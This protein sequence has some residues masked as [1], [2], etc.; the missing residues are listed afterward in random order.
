MN[1]TPKGVTIVK[2]GGSNTSNSVP[3]A[4]SNAAQTPAVP[5]VANGVTQNSPPNVPLVGYTRRAKL[6][7][8]RSTGRLHTSSN[9]HRSMTKLNIAGIIHDQLNYLLLYINFTL[10]IYILGGSVGGLHKSMTRLSSS[11]QINN[12]NNQAASNPPSSTTT[13]SSVSQSKWG[14][15]NTAVLSTKSGISSGGV[16]VTTISPSRILRHGNT[17]S[18]NTQS[19]Q[20]TISQGNNSSV[21]STVST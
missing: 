12:A 1:Q 13:T 3:V 18:H 2:L 15:T 20:I 5:P 19:G 14:S 11:Q 17:R 8:S 21:N 16:T 9:T 4:P 7:D 10:K 6:G